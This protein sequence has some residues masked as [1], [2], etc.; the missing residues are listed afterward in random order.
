MSTCARC[1]A[2]YPPHV[3][4]CPQDGT[5]LSGQRPSAHDLLVGAILAGKYRIDGM[6]GR[7]GMGAVYRATHV[8]LNKTVAVKTITP[9]LVTSTEVAQRFQRE[10]R[11]ASNLEHPNI[12]AVYDLGQSADGA[13]YI[14]MEYVPGQNLKDVIR[15]SGPMAPVRIVRLLRQAASGLARAHTAHIVHRD[16]KPQNLM[17]S[18]AADGHEVVKLVDFGIAK[19]LEE[20]ATQLTS[21]GYSLGTPHYMAP[22]Q[23]AG[24]EVDARA[25]LY[26]LG[27]ILYEM[28]VGDVPFT[29]TSAS[30][31]LVKHLNEP[32]EPP[33]HR[34]PDLQIPPALEA[35]TLKCLEK[36]P[37]RRFQTAEGFTAALESAVPGWE[38]TPSP[39]PTLGE[40]L[41][42]GSTSMAT[43]APVPPPLPP[44]SAASVDPGARPTGP[45]PDAPAPVAS[46]PVP[47]RGSTRRLIAILATL[48]VLFL[49]ALTLAGFA[50][51]RM[52]K[53]RVT[54]A[55]ATIAASEQPAEASVPAIVPDPTPPATDHGD[56][57]PPPPP[58]LQP[59]APSRV[60]APPTAPE[61]S[62]MTRSARERGR[63]STSDAAMT[64]R[65]A[66]SPPAASPSE[67]APHAEPER[68][69]APALPPVPPVYFE[70]AGVPDVCGAL[71]AAFEQA[72]G[73]A[74]LPR[75]G[76]PDGAEVIVNARATLLDTQY[77]QQ[78]GTTFAIQTFGIELQA[79]STRDAATIGMPAAKSFSFDRRFGRERA[80]EQS[81]LMANDAVERI[82]KYWSSRA[83]H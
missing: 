58:G 55:E 8:M 64:D 68:A 72:L 13:L 27:V 4:I 45:V 3:S 82:Q 77:E 42:P 43:A 16:L 35:V 2:N 6:L 40:G 17:V 23:A 67:P 57:A 65:Q 38:S 83:G 75:A 28:L 52:W 79:E 41:P 30:A 24:Q 49:T 20:G 7:G 63:R 74:A 31:V 56:A 15:A 80:S 51:Y 61:P 29:A 36:D 25:D 37:A 46:R 9:D 47:A 22:E 62:A 33:S 34:R 78:F 11:A 60:P 32:P 69:E 12:V 48:A 70:C 5:V 1:G 21:A 19:S 59:A 54:S 44:L 50:A 76:R 71:T 66:S 10:A 18:R 26:S 39:T 53:A 73:R 14:A 81:R